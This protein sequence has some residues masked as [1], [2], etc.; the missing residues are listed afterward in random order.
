ML[1]HDRIVRFDHMNDLK[2]RRLPSHYVGSQRRCRLDDVLTLKAKE[3]TVDAAMAQI[4][5]VEELEN[6]PRA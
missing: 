5:E 2:A 3:E 1:Q 6:G 4:Y